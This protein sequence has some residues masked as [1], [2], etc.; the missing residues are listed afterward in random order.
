MISIKSA[1][2]IEM[3]KK[4]GR[5]TGG[6]LKHAGEV[7]SAGMTTYE[8]DKI[9]NRYIVSHGAKPSFLGYGGFPGSA[10]ISVNDEVIHGIPGPRKL[11]EGD[12]VSVDVGA[13]I[14]GFHG[15]SAKTFIVGDAPDETKALL[16]STEESLYKA[17]S[18]A[19]PGVR[20]G[21]IGFA[22][23][24]YNEDN[25]F[26]VVRQFV[27]HGVGRELHEDPEVPNYGREGRG[28]RLIE[29]M[30]IAIEPMI[31]MGT[32]K[33]YVM[34]DEWTVRTYDGKLS[35]HFEHTIAITKDGALILTDPDIK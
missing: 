2:E 23:Q 31:N 30:V 22:I 27:G 26:S 6:A 10:C 5:I 32:E 34:P 35:A 3:M 8:L 17:I 4:A 15:D 25:G 20:L 29:G 9:I 28:V 16:M 7:L 1:K 13:Y 24:K 19:K 11:L 14:D 33:I 12:I 18:L 21:D